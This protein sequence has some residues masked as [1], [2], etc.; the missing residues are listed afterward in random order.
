MSV[1]TTYVFG[2]VAG[3]SNVRVGQRGRVR[4]AQ[5]TGGIESTDTDNVRLHARHNGDRA[6]QTPLIEP[7]ER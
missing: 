4:Q 7:S 3:L 2:N 1:P 6:R 5:V